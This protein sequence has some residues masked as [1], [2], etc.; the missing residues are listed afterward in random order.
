MRPIRVSASRLKTLKECS[1]LFWYQ[2]RERLPERTHHKTRQGSCIHSIFE[3]LLNPKRAAV[4]RAILHDGFFLV[5]HPALVRFIQLYDAKYGIAP[6]EIHAMEGMLQ[7]TFIAIKPYFDPYFAA[8]DAGESAPFR[9]YT[10]KRFQMEV[11]EAVMSGFID[12]LLVWPDRARVIDL[13]SQAKKWTVVDVS[14]NVQAA[15]YALATYR[16]F[17]FLAATD[18]VM[19]RHAPTKRHPRLHLQS[20]EA[21]SRVHLAG[22][23]SYIESMYGAVNQFSMEDALS[24]PHD[25]LG[26]CERVCQFNR[27]FSYWAVVKKADHSEIVS[28]HLAENKPS[29]MGEDEIV[30]E[31]THK[32]CLIRWRG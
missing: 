15:I 28:T 19:V 6:Y 23:E 3:C 21:P 13:K 30:E 11:G 2:E 16:E 25:D 31:R 10:E 20:V 12:L 8:L 29:A 5:A 26:F 24:H 14:N 22:L 17:G 32:G 1:L 27:P 18:F 7:V 9:Y 4:L